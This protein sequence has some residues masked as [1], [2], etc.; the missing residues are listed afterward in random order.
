MYLGDLVLGCGEGPGGKEGLRVLQLLN[1][2]DALQERVEGPIVHE[3]ALAEPVV[4]VACV[5]V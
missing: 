2:G 3:H 4:C 5:R 1:A